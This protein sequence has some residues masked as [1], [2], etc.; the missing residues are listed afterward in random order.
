MIDDVPKYHEFFHP[1]L[2]ALNSLGGSGTIDEIVEKVVDIV[3]LPAE[4]AEMPHGD[5][6][7]T[8]VAYR[9]SWARTYLKKAGLLD[10]S[11]RGVWS[12]TKKGRDT[13]NV[14]PR[15]IVRRVRAANRKSKAG[16]LAAPPAAAGSEAT[17]Q[18]PDVG[19]ASW[20]VHALSILRKMDP[21]AFERLCQRLLRESGFI[22][23]EVTRRGG[24]GGIDGRGVLRLN[25]L[26]SF[27]VLFQ[28]KRY[29]DAVG[30]PVVRDFRG[31]LVG[32]ADKGLIITTGRF[33]QEA[34]KEAT[35]DGAPPIDLIDGELLVEKL[36]E[37]GLGIETKLV[38]EVIVDP[39]WF[40]GV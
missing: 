9:I 39:S 2:Q 6:S 34:A 17:S 21:I 25:G 32:R 3:G 36:K 18:Q 8:E 5:S 13:G 31:A 20:R 22:E 4:V 33:T 19:P 26:I 35:R 16:Q 12:L 27:T 15:D 38:E 23:V 1:V 14:E 29:A 10:N 40:D 30:A 11:Q 24:D 37:L 28:S 7:Q